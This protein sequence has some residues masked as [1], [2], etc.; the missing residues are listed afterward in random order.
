MTPAAVRDGDTSAAPSLVANQPRISQSTAPETSR[1]VE[2]SD[3]AEIVR[4]DDSAPSEAS[5]RGSL[6][7]VSV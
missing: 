3:H 4:G 2:A 1:P 6:V 5:G 7:D